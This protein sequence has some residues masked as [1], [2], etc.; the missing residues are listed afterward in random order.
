MLPAVV[1]KTMVMGNF[2]KGNMDGEIM[3]SI[4]FV[5]GSV[6]LFSKV[7]QRIFTLI[8]NVGTF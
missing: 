1:L 3:D 7:T 8:I 6:S 4:N 2:D 5:A